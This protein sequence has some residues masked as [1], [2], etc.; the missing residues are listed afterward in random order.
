MIIN[1]KL[2]N[3]GINVKGR[4][5]DSTV[6]AIAKDITKKIKLQFP[7]DDL[8]YLDIYEKIVRTPMYYAIITDGLS[9][10]NYYYKNSSLYFDE[11]K[12]ISDIEEFIFHECIHIIQEYKD[13]KG[14][15]VRIGLCEVNEITIKAMALN[16]GAVQYVVTNALHLQDKEL[17]VYGIVINGKSNY[18]PLITNIINQLAFLLG[19]RILVDST[20]NSNE[21]FKIEI[22][23]NIGEGAYNLI[24][25]NTNEILK[26]KND[27]LEMQKNVNLEEIEYQEKLKE[28]TLEIQKLYLDTQNAIYMGYFNNIFKR[29][30][31]VDDVNE[32]KT[33]LN[34]YSNLIGRTNDYN[35]FDIFYKSYIDKA[36]SKIDDFMNRKS[37]V[38]FGDNFIVRLFRKIKKLFTNSQSEYYK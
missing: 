38:V 36:N 21:N 37:L 7:D 5:E 29:A 18:Y 3:M 35:E 11:S 19:E 13:K 10:A 9:K 8:N 22:I 23:D 12:E 20:L 30:E 31:N 4:V 27:I 28:Y 26:I 2:E 1:K 14:K 15:L 17:T 24:E 25:K 33:T 16:E 6:E 34:K 32:I